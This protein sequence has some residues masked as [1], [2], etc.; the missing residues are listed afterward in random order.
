MNAPGF[1]VAVESTVNVGRAPRLQLNL[2][3]LKPGAPEA[4]ASSAIDAAFA[5]ACRRLSEYAK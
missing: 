3:Q 4:T 5:F 2:E 1:V